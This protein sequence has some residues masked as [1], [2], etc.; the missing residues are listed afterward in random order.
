MIERGEDFGFA[1]EPGQPIRIPGDRCGQHLDGHGPLQIGV[2]RPID[3][4]H[5]AHA[6]L[7]G[8][9]IRAEAGARGQGQFVWIIRGARESGGS[10]AFWIRS[11][12]V[13]S[14]GIRAFRPYP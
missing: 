4:A 10:P 9:F 14:S 1:L 11:T 3:L 5:A 13:R 12:P 8:D 2:S 6:D 7:G